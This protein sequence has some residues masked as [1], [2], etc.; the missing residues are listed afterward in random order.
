MPD[1]DRARLS[2]ALQ[3]AHT[4]RPTIPATLDEIDAEFITAA[5]RYEGHIPESSRAVTFEKVKFGREKGYLGDKCLLRGVTYEPPTPGAPGEVFVK[6]FPTDLVIPVDRCTAMW[7]LEVHFITRMLKDLP[8][9]GG[10]KVPKYYFAECDVEDGKPPRFVILMESINAKPCNVLTCIPVEHALRAAKDL[11]LLHAPFWGWSHK[12]YRAEKDDRGLS[13]FEGYGHMEDAGRTQSFRGIF[14]MGTSLGLEIFGADGPLSESQVKDFSGYIEFFRFW[15]AE[16]WPLLQKRW[17][18]VFTRWKSIPA[19]LIHGDIHAENMFCLE[20]GKNMYIDFQSVGLGPGVRDLAWLIAS[21]LKAE[22]RREHETA[23]VKAYHE[24]LV[25]RGVE[26]AW[27]QCWEDFVFMKIHGCF[28]V[29]LGGGMFAN[30]NFK[31][32]SGIF[33]P[34]PTED[35]VLERTRNCAL[36]SRVV[37]DLRHSNWAAMLCAMVEDPEAC[38]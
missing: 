20:D 16:V 9:S 12:R 24:A 29:L 1:A 11:A 10:F 13:K 17:V 18:S 37:D 38:L 4:K 8:D 5:L 23:V 2:S 32:K 35:A 19:T 28:A 26:Y 34:E 22:E 21:S 36:F 30:K 14:K 31:E 6:L 27:G 3:A 25:T 15:E 7:R 33:A